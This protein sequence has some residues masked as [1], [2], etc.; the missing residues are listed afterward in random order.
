[1]YLNNVYVYVQL[2]LRTSFTLFVNGVKKLKIMINFTIQIP[3]QYFDLDLE[4]K[5]SSLIF[6]KVILVI[7]INK[8]P[9]FILLLFSFYIITLFLY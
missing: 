8:T 1:V 9:N 5:N 7:R 2:K 3:Y 6:K 4:Q